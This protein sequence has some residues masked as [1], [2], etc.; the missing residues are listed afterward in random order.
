MIQILFVLIFQVKSDVLSPE[1]LS[2]ITGSQ[3]NSLS[4]VQITASKPNFEV[5]SS[6]QLKLSFGKKTSKAGEC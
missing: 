2:Q 3:G 1:A 6:T 4:R 5:G